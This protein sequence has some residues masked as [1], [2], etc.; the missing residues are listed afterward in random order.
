METLTLYEKLNAI[1][2]LNLCCEWDNDGISVLPD[3][4]HE[5]KR[6]LVSLDLRDEVI[7][8]AIENEF[9]TIITHHPLIFSKL[10]EL[11]G[12]SVPSEKA[13]KLIRE[14]IAAISFHTR[15]DCIDGGVSDTMCRKLGLEPY[16]AF[17]EGNCARLCNAEKTEFDKFAKK[18]KG[19]FGGAHFSCEKASDT[20]S[21]IAV[22]GG[23]AG[24]FKDDA[25]VSGAD[26]LVCGEMNYHTA[27]DA[28]DA[29]LNVICVGHYESEAPA[30]EHLFE[31]VAEQSGEY[32][33]LY[34]VEQYVI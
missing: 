15:F 31:L 27:I 10:G 34:G 21:R 4:D 9:D 3:K 8:Y 12:F 28:A 18:V 30:L 20:V 24:D 16:A 13:L 5:S 1:I 11:G 25:L 26:T 33:E 2:P 32:T 17:G 19:I 22:C 23:K 29:G 14:D 7:K 6:I